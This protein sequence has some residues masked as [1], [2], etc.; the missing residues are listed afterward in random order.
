MSKIPGRVVFGS[1]EVERRL[2][3][4]EVVAECERCLMRGD[5]MVPGWG[6]VSVRLLVRDLRPRTGWFA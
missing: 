1:E 4:G 3:R 6:L 5:K 2:M